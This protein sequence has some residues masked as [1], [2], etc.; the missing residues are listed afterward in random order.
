MASAGEEDR[1]DSELHEEEEGGPVKSF[2]DH[3]ED[4]RW[5]LIKCV[6]AAGICV[7][8]CLIGANHVVR[9]IEK[10]LAQA[11]ALRMASNPT[12]TLFVGTN[13]VGRFRPGTNSLGTYFFGSNNLHLALELTPVATPSG[14]TIF[15][16]QPTTNEVLVKIARTPQQSLVNLGPAA[17]FWIAFQVALYGGII[18]ASPLL[19]YFIGSFVL[20]ALK[21]KERKYILRGFAIGTGLFLTGVGF[22]YFVL[23]PIALSAAVQYSE[24]MGFSAEQWRAEEYISFV[25]KFML[26]MGL[27]F[28]LPVVILTLVKIGVLNADRLAAMRR[29]MIVINL[30]LGAVLTTPEVITQVLM[31]IPL[32]GLYE[33]SVWIARYWELD[34]AGKRRARRNLI[35]VVILLAAFVA[36]GLYFYKHPEPVVKMWR[37]MRGG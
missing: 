17:A 13:V 11:A 33:L 19:I 1:H 12:A 22:C 36:A 2:L 9:V 31:F 18:I 32:Q 30:F 5:V 21:I 34:A 24:W 26:G 7:L 35:I 16:F 37:Q 27:G 6:V 25:C 23:M 29:Y 20:P 4:L 28:E 10:P 3:L 8:V 15:A 14:G